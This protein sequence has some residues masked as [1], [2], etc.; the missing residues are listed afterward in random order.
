VELFEQAVKEEERLGI[1][2]PAGAAERHEKLSAEMEALNA[3]RK[4]YLR[5]A[6]RGNISDAELDAMLSEIDGKRQRVSSELRAA[7]QALAR[8]RTPPSY[9]PVHAEWYEDP[10]A[11]HPGEVLTH[12]SSPEQVRTAYRRYGVRF[13]VD[14]EGTLTMRMELPLSDPPSYGSDNHTPM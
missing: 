5:L 12:A 2:T 11:I 8:R 9:S 1:R 4:N 6:A 7:E 10:E 13:E 3:E 14:A